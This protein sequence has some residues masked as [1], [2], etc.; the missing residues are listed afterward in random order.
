MIPSPCSGRTV[1][2]HFEELPP[3]KKNEDYYKAIRLPISLAI[4]EQ[5]LN[6]HEFST[7]S[8]LEA[9]FKRMVLNAKEYYSRGSQV[10]EDSERIRK[11]LSNYMT[12][13]NPAYKLV[14]GYSCMPTP[15]PDES[16]DQA[17]EANEE[18]PKG[19]G[20]E[21]VENGDKHDDGSDD[22]HDSD[23]GLGGRRTSRRS[24]RNSVPKVPEKAAG[25]KAKPDHEYEDVPYKGLTF[26]QAQ[27]KIVEELIRKEDD[28]YAPLVSFSGLFVTG[29]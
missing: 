2:D 27:E 13:T 22:D 25:S 28:E 5:K 12:K 29:C 10:F 19:E 23:D 7:L 15:I 20:D 16:E 26:Q 1:A 18:T 4:I 6:N 3:R 17:G 14:N 11:A 24:K 8:E 9:Y 21:D